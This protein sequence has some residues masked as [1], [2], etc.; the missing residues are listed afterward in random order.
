MLGW[1]ENPVKYANF[2]YKNLRKV[3]QNHQHS[4]TSCHSKEKNESF[5]FDHFSDGSNDHYVQ[6]E[7]MQSKTHSS[8]LSSVC[9]IHSNSLQFTCSE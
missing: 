3:E 8:S 4:I 6:S 2:W 1:N 7:C 5:L 9:Q